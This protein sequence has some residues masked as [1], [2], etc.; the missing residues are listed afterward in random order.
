MATASTR[1]SL[2][3]GVVFAFAIGLSAGARAAEPIMPISPPQIFAPGTISGPANDAD[4]AF[5]PDGRSVVFSRDGALMISEKVGKTWS[6]PRIAP[7]SG[8]W[9]DLQPTMSPDGCFLVFV[10]N[11]PLH[12]TDTDHPKGNLWRVDRTGKSWG[13]PE[14]LP[15]TVNAD[16]SIWGP[17][18]AADGTLYFMR[19]SDPQTPWH[20]WRSKYVDRNYAE[21]TVLSFGDPTTQDVD[22]AVA[23]DQSYIVFS[24][25][26]PATEAHEHLYMAFRDGDGWGTPIDLGA[27]VNGDGSHDVNESR[28]GPDGETLYFTTDRTLT[29]TYPRSR[30]QAEAD[31]ERISRWDNGDTNI[32]FVSLK[33]WQ[34]KREGRK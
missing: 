24:S 2:V 7:F 32:W 9:M 33:P 14:P 18:I 21:S 20:L 26:H 10:S 5:T 19:R 17:S 13:V 30:A 31:Q 25:K 27:A 22:P 11:R 34:A 15:A 28:L 1:A 16:R 4:A 12:P 3:T 29:V 23:P 8:T 6:K